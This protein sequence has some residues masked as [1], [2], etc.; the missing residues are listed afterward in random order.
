MHAYCGSVRKGVCVSRLYHLPEGAGID[1]MDAR[2]AYPLTGIV[3]GEVPGGKGCQQD[4]SCFESGP[5]R[6]ERESYRWG[7]PASD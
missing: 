1:H 3:V 7:I 4:Q 6:D 5:M 2:E